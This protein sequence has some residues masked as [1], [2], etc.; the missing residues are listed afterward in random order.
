MNA[1]TLIQEARTMGL[2]LEAREGTLLVQ[3]KSRCS[4]DFASLLRKHKPELLRELSRNDCRGAG[5]IPPDDLPLN[6][7]MPKPTPEERAR[8]IEAMLRQGCDKPGPLTAWLV[9]RETAYYDGPGR[10]W[11]CDL[12]SYAAARDALCWQAGK[13]EGELRESETRE[14]V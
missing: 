5:E 11:D 7:S 14:R 3:P 4:S 6:S 1:T 10:H 2:T 12:F 9:R 13:A 8:V